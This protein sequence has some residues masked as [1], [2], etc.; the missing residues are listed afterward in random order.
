MDVASTT[1]RHCFRCVTCQVTSGT[2]PYIFVSA[3]EFINHV[4]PHAYFIMRAD[5]FPGEQT[6]QNESTINIYQVPPMWLRNMID[7][8]ITKL[9]YPKQ[10]DSEPYF[11]SM[12]SPSST[13]A[14]FNS[15]LPVYSPWKHSLPLPINKLFVQW[16][17]SQLLTKSEERNHEVGNNRNYIS[18]LCSR[19]KSD[20]ETLMRRKYFNHC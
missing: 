19:V 14:S 9:V 17:S 3:L 16:N 18:V 10:T 20:M 6:E 12:I 15:C 13:I 4:Y 7:L 5:A 2:F 11:T 8:I 1:G